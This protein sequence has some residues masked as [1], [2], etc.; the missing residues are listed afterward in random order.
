M[1]SDTDTSKRDRE[2]PIYGFTEKLLAYLWFCFIAVALIYPIL[3][4]ST[5]QE[6]MSLLNDGG[7]PLVAFILG[8]SFIL[9]YRRDLG[10]FVQT[11]RNATTIADDIQ[12][13]GNDIK[14]VG[15]RV[16]KEI[17]ENLKSDLT[18]IVA[19]T[20]EQVKTQ[21]SDELQGR[22]K[23]QVTEF[24]GGVNESV[25]HLLNSMQTRIEDAL[26]KSV[27][28]IS[29]SVAVDETFEVSDADSNDDQTIAELRNKYY[30]ISDTAVNI[31]NPLHSAIYLKSDDGEFPLVSRGGGNRKDITR[32][33]GDLF[34]DELVSVSSEKVSISREEAERIVGFMTEV[35]K[36]F[37]VRTRTKVSELNSIVEKLEMQ[38]EQISQELMKAQKAV[39]SSHTQRDASDL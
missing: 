24:S 14:E 29:K 13:V 8:P 16:R 25:G 18:K 17:G 31:F 34:V 6:I 15:E 32:D 38:Q 7:F 4:G 30:S 33:F 26:R 12:R 19:D 3:N 20:S 11:Y 39:S 35:F 21:I 10:N 37:G 9:L 1:Q 36:A 22:L 23:N 28:Q 27:D 5:V 2:T